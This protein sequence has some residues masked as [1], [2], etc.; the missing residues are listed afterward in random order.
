LRLAD[1]RGAVLQELAASGLAEHVGPGARIAIGVGSRGI[2]NLAAIVGSVVDFWKAR[3][4]RPFLFPA[5]GSHAGAT[6]EGQEQLLARYGIDAQTMGCPEV[7][8][9]DVAPTG[10]TESGIETFADKAALE[11]D[12]ILLINRIKWHTSFQGPVESGLAKMIAIGLGKIEGAK[13]CHRHAR[14]LGMTNVI[15]QVARHNIATGKILGGVGILEDA[16]HNTAKVAALPA[17]HLIDRETELFALVQ[18]WKAKIPLPLDILVLDEIGKNISG[19]GMDPK[20]V[21]R[22]VR[23]QYNPWPGIH[24]IQRIL[25][26]DLSAPTHGNAVGIGMAD[27]AHDRAVAKVDSEVTWVNTAT[28][29]SLAAA[30]IPMHYPSDRRCLEILA[31]T[32]E[33]AP[34]NVTIGW[35]RNSQELGEFA[36]TE[37]LRA[38]IERD[39]QLEIVGSAF[40]LDFDSA[41]NLGSSPV[42]SRLH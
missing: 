29:G 17:A 37:N 26:R 19:T 15:Q 41:G 2:T 10:V 28:S 40:A 12:G 34:E 42:P 14:S 8:C 32:V 7:S 39:P 31:Q 24:K 22:G 38:E 27:V 18:Q 13:H 4:C 16:Y 9:M 1:V 21:N 25:V 36:L 30:R 23:G 11:S 6:A 35:I 20:V 5:M 33:S 3:G